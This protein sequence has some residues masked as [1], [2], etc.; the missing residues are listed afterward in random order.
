MKPLFILFLF[1]GS[2]TFEGCTK[3]NEPIAKIDGLD[4]PDIKEMTLVSHKEFRL[5]GVAGEDYRYS[6]AGA[7]VQIKAVG[8]V[9]ES[10][11]EKAV[12]L[13]EF[14]LERPFREERSPYPG[15]ITTG[16]KCT[17]G[18]RPRKTSKSQA[19]SR[20]W[21]AEIYVSSRKTLVCTEEDFVLRSVELIVY[22]K[23]SRRL[24]T[25]NGTYPKG[26]SAPDWSSWLS[27]VS[28]ISN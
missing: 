16:V 21:R 3:K 27:S 2:L 10:S 23:N 26:S 7:E 18:F 1:F 4:I 24:Y 5:K 28:C 20:T 22:C 12:E 25:V 14:E 6:R 15:A 19:N 8:G 11:F 13:R 9:E 17:D